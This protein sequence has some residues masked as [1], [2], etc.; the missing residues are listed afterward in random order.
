G[1]GDDD[2]EGERAG[3]CGLPA[4]DGPRAGTE[5]AMA[6]LRPCPLGTDAGPCDRAA[7]RRDDDGRDA[8]LR[9]RA[10]RRGAIR[11]LRT[12]DARRA[13]RM[14]HAWHLPW[15]CARKKSPSGKKTVK[16]CTLGDSAMEHN[17]YVGN[18]RR[19]PCV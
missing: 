16:R 13:A 7:P 4:G 8:V 12:V 2:R 18:R 17:R 3:V 10:L 6:R 14:A 1:G 9:S 11:A 19:L 5:R 15:P